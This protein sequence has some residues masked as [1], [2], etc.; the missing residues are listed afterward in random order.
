[1]RH[2]ISPSTAMKTATARANTMSYR[3]LIALPSAVAAVGG[4]SAE[5]APLRKTIPTM[6]IRR[7][8]T[9]PATIASEAGRFLGL[10]DMTPRLRRRD[11]DP[12]GPGTGAAGQ[13]TRTADPPKASRWHHSAGSLERA[14]RPW[15]R[16]PRCLR[17]APPRGRAGRR[18]VRRVARA[19]GRRARPWP[20]PAG[21]PDAGD[22]R[23]RLAVRAAR[24]R[25]APRGRARLAGDRHPGGPAPS[26]SADPGPSERGVPRRP[27]RD[28]GRAAV[29]DRA[30]R[31]DAVLGPHGPAPAAPPRGR[32]AAGPG[33]AGDAAAP[34]GEPV[35]PQA[36]APARPP[37]DADRRARASGRRLDD[38]HARHLGQPLLATVRPGARERGR[39]PAG[40]RGVPR[41]GAHVLV[42]GGRGRSRTA[43]PR[44]P[45]AGPVRAP[46]NAPQLVPGDGDPLRLD[47]ALPALRL[48][49]GAVRHPAAGRSTAC[50][51]DHVAGRRRG[52]H[53]RR[54]RD[55]GGLD[56]PRRA[57]RA[58]RGPAG[59][60]AA[61]A[62]PGAGR[63]ARRGSNQRGFGTGD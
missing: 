44:P 59:G 52:V 21:P 16:A 18:R 60:C 62:D 9:P 7:M 27:R 40:A 34:G 51:R 22:A 57:R 55:R 19:A 30:L 17:P 5:P 12:R 47:P 8:T 6:A 13:G 58:G 25:G 20:H 28:R 46:P 4:Y 2:T 42:A 50:R 43:P 63:P 26:R 45:G 61:G 53:P 11:R 14:V 41:L 24:R 49:R 36:L 48:P 10:V 32:S 29:R 31:H 39:P 15:R 54:A 33:R 35:G 37:L 1:M 23:A 3:L 38:V 56:A